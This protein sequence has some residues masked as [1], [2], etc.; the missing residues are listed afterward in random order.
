MQYFGLCAS[1]AMH[2][3]MYLTSVLPQYLFNDRSVGAG[4]RQYQFSGSNILTL[5]NFYQVG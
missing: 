4:W 5:A 2:H 3:A 1:A